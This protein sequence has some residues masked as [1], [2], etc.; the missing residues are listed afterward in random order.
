MKKLTTLIILI[1]ALG[2]CT[3]QKRLHTGGYSIDFHSKHKSVKADLEAQ[4]AFTADVKPEIRDGKSF[5]TADSVI[6]DK[7]E[8]A[9]PLENQVFNHDRPS[10]E[11]KVIGRTR[12]FLKKTIPVPVLETK[13]KMTEMKKFNQQQDQRS[14]PSIRDWDVDWASVFGVCALTAIVVLCLIYPAFLA[15]VELILGLA[16]LVFIVVGII[17]IFAALGNFQWFWSGR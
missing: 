3:I 15:V 14:R 1:L 17:W 9:D 6:N 12:T 8:T 13:Q 2:S 10:F 7:I 4:P 5:L 11:K 16:L